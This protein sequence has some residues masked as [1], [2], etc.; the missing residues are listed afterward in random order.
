MIGNLRTAGISLVAALA[1]GA[2]IASPASAQ[3]GK[4]TS[5]GPVTLGGAESGLA[6]N[7]MTGPLGT[8]TC[9][10]GTGTGHKYSATPHELVPSGATTFTMTPHQGQCFAHIPIFGTRPVTVTTN[11]CDLVGHIGETTGGENTYNGTVD[12]V[13]P[14]GK[15]LEAHIYKSGSPHTDVN[16][17]CTIKVKPQNGFSGGHITSTPGPGTLY[18]KG[19][20]TGIHTENTGSLCGTGTSTTAQVHVDGE[21]EGVNSVGKPTGVTVTH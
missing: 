20:G 21:V 1:L 18:I 7:V 17:I 14:V 11:G 16:S 19:T 13:C 9:P 2:V 15:V 6:F 10:G 8:I 12:L 3:Q 4:L 5:D